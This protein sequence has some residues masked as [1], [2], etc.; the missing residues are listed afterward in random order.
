M[1]RKS[2]SEAHQI[3][4]SILTRLAAVSVGVR[5]LC[6]TRFRRLLRNTI[7]DKTK[8]PS[9]FVFLALLTKLGFA[10]KDQAADWVAGVKLNARITS[11]TFD[12]VDATMR[13]LDSGVEPLTEFQRGALVHHISETLEKLTL[14]PPVFV[15]TFAILDALIWPTTSIHDP[16]LCNASPT[17]GEPMLAFLNSKPDIILEKVIMCPRC[18]MH[19]LAVYFRLQLLTLWHRKESCCSS[20]R[21]QSSAVSAL[22]Q[23]FAWYLAAATDCTHLRRSLLQASELREETLRLIAGWPG[24]PSDLAGR[25]LFALIEANKNEVE[26][27]ATESFKLDFFT[28]ESWDRSD[29]EGK[30]LL[31]SCRIQLVLE[32]CIH[33]TEHAAEEGIIRVFQQLFID[34][35]LVFQ[36]LNSDENVKEWVEHNCRLLFNSSYFLYSV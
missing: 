15:A 21:V 8:E 19:I 34:C 25:I 23:D 13:Y 16:K 11:A 33:V 28:K 3:L 1:I 5:S 18:P 27:R 35:A 29:N 32:L 4:H 26:F 12:W 14:P 2:S 9:K 36:R 10:L 6:D 24:W 22:I 31:I 7:S 17:I 20:Q 30:T